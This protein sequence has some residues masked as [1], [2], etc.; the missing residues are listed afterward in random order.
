MEILDQAAGHGIPFSLL[1]DVLSSGRRFFE[2][3]EEEKLRCSSK[4]E[5]FGE[6]YGRDQ[7]KVQT[8]D[9]TDR[10]LLKVHPED[11][12]KLELWPRNPTSFR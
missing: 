1:E 7:V 4:I 5:G 12:R 8:L 9:W 2:L 11:Q 6:G 10:I 3:P